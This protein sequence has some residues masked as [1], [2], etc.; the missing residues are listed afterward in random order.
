MKKLALWLSM[1]GILAV[2]AF[3][4]RGPS[5]EPGRP[6]DDVVSDTVKRAGDAGK[7]GEKA[8]EAAQNAGREADARAD[9]SADVLS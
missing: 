8:G 7:S 2:A 1:T 9:E 6:V 3:D 4:Q 5:G